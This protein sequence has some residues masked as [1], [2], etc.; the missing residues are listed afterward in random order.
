MSDEEWNQDLCDDHGTALKYC[1]CPCLA[2][3]AISAVDEYLGGKLPSA[4]G[5]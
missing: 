3:D 1:C 5:L 2:G 4:H